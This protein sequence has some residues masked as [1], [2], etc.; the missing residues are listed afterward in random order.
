[1]KNKT[2][3]FNVALYRSNSRTTAL[4]Y[5]RDFYINIRYDEYFTAINDILFE[6]NGAYTYRILGLMLW[7]LRLHIKDIK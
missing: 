1:M 7:K 3:K 5:M 6:N 2:F 4:K